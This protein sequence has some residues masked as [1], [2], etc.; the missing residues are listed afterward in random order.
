MGVVVDRR[1]LVLPKLHLPRAERATIEALVEHISRYQPDHIFQTGGL[2]SAPL[3]ATA[4]HS[5][6]FA[7]LHAA[8][9][10]PITVL[11]PSMDDAAK[12]LSNM[13]EHVSVGDHEVTDEWTIVASDL[14]THRPGPAGSSALDRARRRR[15]SIIVG[16][17]GRLGIGR[18]TVRDRHG[19]R[20]T[21]TGVEAGSLDRPDKHERHP[22]AQG[23]VVMEV[24]DDDVDVRCIRLANGRAVELSPARSRGDPGSQPRADV[25][26]DIDLPVVPAV[27][28]E[29]DARVEK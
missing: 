5:R 29:P 4:T 3:S 15:R 12:A 10:C 14:A 16:D 17:T 25:V 13:G 7:R 28:P 24:A 23:W 6:F 19:T 26:R 20:R 8:S 11:R 9:P 21:L 27:Q 2:A 18:F 22:R 1:Y